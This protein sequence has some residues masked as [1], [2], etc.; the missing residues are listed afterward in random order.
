[1]PKQPIVINVVFGVELD[2]RKASEGIRYKPGFYMTSNVTDQSLKQFCIRMTDWKAMIGYPPADK[3]ERLLTEE[4]STSFYGRNLHTY[5]TY[6]DRQREGLSIY[7][8]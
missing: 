7:H 1:M 4:N 6:I 3:C 8:E 5:H 2:S